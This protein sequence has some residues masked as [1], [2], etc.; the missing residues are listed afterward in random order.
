[1][2]SPPA[3]QKIPGR[4]PR[5]WHVLDHDIASLD[6]ILSVPAISG[7]GL[8]PAMAGSWQGAMASV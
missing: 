1:M 3:G 2:M 4:A 8:G 5:A 6:G 7:G